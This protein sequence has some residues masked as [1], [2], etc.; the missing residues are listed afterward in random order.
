MSD[1]SIQAD[2][3]VPI[4]SR[5]FTEDD[6]RAVLNMLNGKQVVTAEDGSP[7]LDEDGSVKL[8]DTTPAKN[9]GYGAFDTPGAAR[10]AGVTLNNMLE[11]LGATHRYA[12]TTRVRGGKTLGVLL[13][14]P[15]KTKGEKNGNTPE[16]TPAPE[17]TKRTGGRRSRS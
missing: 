15:A 10:S 2:V 11:A 13:N 16:D 4:R 5:T 12:V 3:E 8:E 9:V 17:P 6:A 14:K 7:E 1:I